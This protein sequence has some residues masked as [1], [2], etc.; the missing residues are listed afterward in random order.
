MKISICVSPYRR[1][2]GIRRLLLA[3][4]GLVLPE[5][6]A[7]IEV[8]VVDNE[9]AP[10][11]RAVCEETS[12]RIRWP[13]TYAAE[14]RRG[15]SFA[16]NTALALA[17]DDATCIAILDDDEV[18]RRDWLAELLR[19]QKATA[20]D[21]VTGP[22][23][24]HFERGPTEW[25]ET[26]GFFAPQR[27]PD[28]SP[29]PYAYTN[30]VIFRASL[31][32]DPRLVPAF[33][34]EY[35]L[36]GGEDQHFFARVKRA[37][38]RLHWADAA[39]VTEWVPPDRANAGWLGRRQFRIGNALA[40]IQA[41]LEPGVAR[42]FRRASRAGKEVLAAAVSLPAARSRGRVAWVRTCQRAAFSLGVI[43]GL[44]GGSYEGYR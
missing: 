31:L 17:G 16:R 27:H 13:V 12:K 4:D 34:E 5:R 19:V 36:T 8:I 35:G 21:V 43:W 20:A 39:E 15:L 18:P 1:P 7:R 23:V 30:N 6:D 38:Y 29:M 26:G 37:G 3:L 32:R 44:V 33:A 24:P 41:E 25:I 11:V 10:G 42:A 9:P 2:E 14:P 40:R 22:A 28:G